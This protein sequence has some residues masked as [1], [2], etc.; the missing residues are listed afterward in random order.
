MLHPWQFAKNLFSDLGRKNILLQPSFLLCPV[1]REAGRGLCWFWHWVLQK[2]VQKH[3]PP[4]F[5]C[6]ST[7]TLHHGIW[8]GQIAP[9]SNISFTCTW[10]SSTKREGI[11]WNLSLKGSSST[12]LI[13]HFDKSVQ[14][15]SPGSRKKMS[16][17]SANRAWAAAW[18]LSDHL[19]RP[20]K[21]S[22][23]K[24]SF[25]LCSTIILVHWIPCISSNFSSVRVTST[26]GNA[27]TATIWTIL[28]PFVIVIGVAIRFFHY[29]CNSLAPRNHFGVCVHYTQAM[30]QVGSI[31]TFQRLGHY[32]HVPSQE[33][34]VCLAVYYFE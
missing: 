34:G 17:Y 16:W 33:Q 8:L 14:P 5:L 25:F 26:G 2:S 10:T 9:T 22:L 6:T 18:F 12:T 29:H 20:D 31:T 27:F 30:R 28:T 1:F 11:L 7:T 24:S 15:S 3:R 21:T 19:S 32:I 4:S 23:W 13:S